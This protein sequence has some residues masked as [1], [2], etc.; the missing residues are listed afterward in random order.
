MGHPPSAC[1]RLTLAGGG[2]PL[3]ETG[4]TCPR[5]GPINSRGSTSTR[6]EGPVPLFARRPR[7]APEE[8]DLGSTSVAGHR[9]HRKAPSDLQDSKIVAA[10]APY[11][12][13]DRRRRGPRAHPRCLGRARGRCGRA[14][15]RARSKG[16]EQDIQRLTVRAAA[17]PE[18]LPSCGAT[19]GRLGGPVLARARAHSR[20]G[21]AAERSERLQEAPPGNSGQ[22]AAR[23]VRVS[24]VR[25][26]SRRLQAIRR[27]QRTA[28]SVDLGRRQ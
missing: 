20:G 19:A 25:R 22:R 10:A 27:R 21:Q 8:G 24:R 6:K 7:P 11:C 16:A 5:W 28:R 2:R 15:T 12:R 14:Q 3:A 13:G 17:Q 23:R 26:R 18:R 9:L 1:V 4:S